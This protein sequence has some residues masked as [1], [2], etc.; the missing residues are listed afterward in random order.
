MKPHTA[1][2]FEIEMALVELRVKLYGAAQLLKGER[3][4]ELHELVNE[5]TDVIEF[6]LTL[7]REAEPAFYTKGRGR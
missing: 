6:E 7:E 2:D 4:A 5:V 3:L 1:T